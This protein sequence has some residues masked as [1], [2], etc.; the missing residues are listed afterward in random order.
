M[1]DPASIKFVLDAAELVI[2]HK[3]HGTV[4]MQDLC[5]MAYNLVQLQQ[6]PESFFVELKGAVEK[7]FEGSFDATAAPA[8]SILTAW[9][10]LL[11]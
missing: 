10:R 9:L 7:E 1:T 4:L 2:S 11:L 5:V 6:Y 8:G 3:R